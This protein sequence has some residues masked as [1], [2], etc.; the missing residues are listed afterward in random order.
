MREQ[1]IYLTAKY[2]LNY[3]YWF[4]KKELTEF[5][6]LNENWTSSALVAVFLLPFWVTPITFHN[7]KQFGI[8]G[9]IDELF[10]FFK[11]VHGFFVVND[12][13]AI[14]IETLKWKP[15]YLRIP[16]LYA[17]TGGKRAISWPWW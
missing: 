5:K 6:N 3:N 2:H 16:T 13:I 14:F 11:P 15:Q 7:C 4:S 1:V 10:D 17:K 8:R 12:I 9:T